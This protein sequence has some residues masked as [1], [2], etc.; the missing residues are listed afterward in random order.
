VVELILGIQHDEFGFEINV[1]DQPDLLEIAAF[2]H[3]GHGGFWVALDDER[4]VGTIALRDIGDYQAALRTRGRLQLT[5]NEFLE[6]PTDVIEQ[7]ER[8]LAAA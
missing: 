1:D 7:I 5:P 8:G 3:S 6:C 2:Y 4:V